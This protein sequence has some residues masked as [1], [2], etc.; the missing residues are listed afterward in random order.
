VLANLH[1]LAMSLLAAAPTE[2]VR[3]VAR[4]TRSRISSAIDS[5][6]TGDELLLLLLLLLLFSLLL[7]T[8]GVTS[9]YAS[10]RDMASNSGS[11]SLKTWVKAGAW[12]DTASIEERLQNNMPSHLS[13]GLSRLRVPAGGTTSVTTGNSL[14]KV[15]A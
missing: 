12:A 4:C 5:G 6:V 14:G 13:H 10:S 9:R 3:P 11:Y 7:L 1:I 2:H 15:F 8:R